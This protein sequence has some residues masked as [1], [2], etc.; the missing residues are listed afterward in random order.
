MAL[1]GAY[2]PQNGLYPFQL[3]WV[4]MGKFHALLLR[5]SFLHKSY[6]ETAL[7]PNVD[8]MVALHRERD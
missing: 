1:A 7:N 3:K 2:T 4:C 5:G 8:A 6:A